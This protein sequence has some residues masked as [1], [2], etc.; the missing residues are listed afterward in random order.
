[1][2][3]YKVKCPHCKTVLR[4]SKTASGSP[5]GTCPKCGQPYVDRECYEPALKPYKK[6]TTASLLA[7]SVFVGSLFS[8]GALMFYYI[9]SAAR[10]VSGAE[11]LIVYAVAFC[12]I[13]GYI[14]IR[15]NKSRD[16]DDARA[17]KEWEAS[18]AR[19]QNKEYALA[20]KKAGFDVPDK[21]LPKNTGEKE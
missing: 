21:Y 14:F 12:I 20:V 18:D 1:M 4:Y 15:M 9:C 8:F 10:G 3:H 19:L 11:A 6:E 13:T 2:T 5:F 16:E 17:L 7:L